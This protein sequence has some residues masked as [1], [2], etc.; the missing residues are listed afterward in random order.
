MS[1]RCNLCP[2]EAEAFRVPWPLDPIGVELMKEHL[3]SEHGVRT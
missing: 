1:A 2:D 3:L